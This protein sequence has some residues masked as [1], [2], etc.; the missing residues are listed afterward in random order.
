[1]E[2]EG[3]REKKEKHPHET[4]RVAASNELTTEVPAT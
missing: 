3:E 4:H 1:M 2:G